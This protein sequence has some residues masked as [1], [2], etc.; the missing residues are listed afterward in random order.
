MK[1]KVFFAGRLSG[2][3]EKLPD[4]RFSFQYVPEYL[5]DGSPISL[6]LPLQEE[7]Y[8]SNGLHGYFSGLLTEGWLREVQSRTMKIDEKDEFRFL[9][10]TGA[11][12]P[13]LMA[14]EL[15]E[16]EHL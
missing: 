12:L 5:I 9:I 7:P 6:S 1:A 13:G 3:L 4:G 14:V 10:R 2:I 8:L 11:D 16:N 15:D